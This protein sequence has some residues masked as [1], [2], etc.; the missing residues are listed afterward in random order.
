MIGIKVPMAVTALTVAGVGAGV[1][2]SILTR[3]EQPQ[4]QEDLA[5]GQRQAGADAG[6][7]AI[8]TALAPEEP[9]VA[10]EPPLMERSV[11]G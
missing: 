6:D 2:A 4:A 1:A 5:G 10:A 11:G 3:E 8:D 9:L 7:N